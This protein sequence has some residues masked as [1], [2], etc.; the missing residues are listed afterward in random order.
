VLRGAQGELLPRRR[1]QAQLRAGAL[2]VPRGLLRGALLPG[3]ASL[4]AGAA[5]ARREAQQGGLLQRPRLQAWAA[6]GLLPRQR[7]LP[8]VGVARRALQERRQ[9]A[10][11]LPWRAPVLQ[12]PGLLLPWQAQGQRGQWQPLAARWPAPRA[13]GLPLLRRRQQK[14]W[15]ARRACCLS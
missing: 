6:Q 10:L 14:P 9:G 2:Q 4:Q 7:A 1:P 3:Q 12:G 15:P 11:L 5:R 13:P 8:Q